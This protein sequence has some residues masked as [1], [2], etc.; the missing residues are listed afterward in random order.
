MDTTMF[1]ASLWGPT[2]LAIG[3][4]VLIN[5]AFYVKLYRELD[6]DVLA[7]LIF[8]MIAVPAGI[9]QVYFHNVW[10]TLPQ[11]IVSLLGWATLLKG[12]AFL[13]APQFVDSMGDMWADK[14]LVPA[15]SIAMLAIGGYLTWFAYLA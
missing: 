15:A 3:L 8:G 5:R 4:G 7:T 12:A 11:I 2:V 9:A 1:L 13:V 14:K 6:K 10:D